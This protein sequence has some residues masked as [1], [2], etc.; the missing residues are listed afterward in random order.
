MKRL[1]VLLL[2]ASLGASAAPWSTRWLVTLRR[3][4]DSDLQILLNQPS[5][6]QTR[7]AKGSM[8]LW[9]LPRSQSA[10]FGNS[11]LSF[12]SDVQINFQT[13]SDVT[14]RTLPIQTTWYVK[15]KEQT[16][17]SN[18]YLRLVSAGTDAQVTADSVADLYISDAS[19][20][21]AVTVGIAIFVD[22]GPCTGTCLT[23]L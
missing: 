17:A 19:V 7:L 20:Y 6:G 4:T 18:Y 11:A 2:L 14:A 1:V 21:S 13:S 15:Y 22:F 5:T 12:G 3:E 8:T 23:S 9:R 10:L 16:G